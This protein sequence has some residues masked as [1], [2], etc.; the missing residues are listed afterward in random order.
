MITRA[1]INARFGQRRVGLRTI[2][3]FTLGRGVGT[4]ACG[5]PLKPTWSVRELLSS[6]P[7][8]CLSPATF[9]RLHELSALAPLPECTPEYDLMKKEL[10]E[11]VRLVEA[12]KLIDVERSADDSIPDG[13]ICAEGT[14]I[15]LTKVVKWKNDET[16]GRELLKHAS[17]T[18]DG[19]YIVETDRKR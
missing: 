1:C 12:V 7:S 4:D 11:L 2:K 3:N 5:I 10:D 9:K 16:H 18:V 19:M 8:P 17:R 13:R 15:P 6:Y 14:G